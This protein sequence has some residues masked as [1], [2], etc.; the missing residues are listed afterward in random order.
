MDPYNILKYVY[1]CMYVCMCVILGWGFVGGYNMCIVVMDACTCI[2]VLISSYI[3]RPDQTL[4]LSAPDH[5]HNLVR[6][7]TNNLTNN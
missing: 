4:I 6:A 3:A 5:N 2:Y 7:K 1:V